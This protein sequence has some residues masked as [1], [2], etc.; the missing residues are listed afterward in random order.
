MKKGFTLAEALITLGIIGI[1]AALSL[2]ALNKA[3]PDANKIK[4]LKTYDA[5]CEVVKSLANNTKEYPAVGRKSISNTTEYDLTKYP[6]LNMYTSVNNDE[7]KSISAIKGYS[8]LTTFCKLL[9]WS[10]NAEGNETCSYNTLSSDPGLPGTNYF[11]YQ[12]FK[13]N[14]GVI[15]SITGREAPVIKKT[16][17]TFGMNVIIDI[18]GAEAP[19]CVYNSNNCKNPDRFWFFVEAD[20]NIIPADG[21][22]QYYIQTRKSP[23]IK[24]VKDSDVPNPKYWNSSKTAIDDL[25]VVS[26]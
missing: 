10:F 12:S 26:E 16:G 24:A 3:K 21:M 9:A 15:F 19:N 22:G 20:G 18:N 17:S 11:D 23:R 5:I 25:E 7:E 6:L 13:T 1:V 14:S 4:Y 2:P 8:G